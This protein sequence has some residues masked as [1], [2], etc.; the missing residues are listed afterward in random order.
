LNVP[1]SWMEGNSTMCLAIPAK[2]TA[3]SGS[4]AEVDVMGNRTSAD[5]SVIEEV[6][7]G[8]YIL[9]HA[10]LAIQKYDEAEALETIA[11]FREL[12]EAM[13]E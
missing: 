3:I 10:G 1:P 12:A 11:L 4:V 5:I 13:G 8:D 7:V 6:R 9:I 2:V